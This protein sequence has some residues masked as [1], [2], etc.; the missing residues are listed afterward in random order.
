MRVSIGRLHF[1]ETTLN[2]MRKKGRPNPEQ[3]YNWVCW[4]IRDRSNHSSWYFQVF[5]AGGCTGGGGGGSQQ[6]QGGGAAL[7]PRHREDHCQGEKNNILG[8][9]PILFAHKKLISHSQ[10]SNPGLF[11]PEQEASW[12][13]QGGSDTVCKTL[14]VT[15]E[16]LRDTSY[17]VMIFF[18]FRFTTWVK[19]A[20]GLITRQRR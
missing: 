3:R 8:Q 15:V 13:K 20:L 6:L 4:S 17:G 1:S 12:S 9:N 18:L 11:E 14:T 7:L 19:L 2:N 5:P 16:V 10:A